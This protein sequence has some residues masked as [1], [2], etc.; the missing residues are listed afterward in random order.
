VVGSLTEVVATLLR[1]IAMNLGLYSQCVYM[2]ISVDYS[3]FPSKP[4]LQQEIGSKPGLN[5]ILERAN[6]HFPRRVESIDR[7]LACEFQKFAIDGYC[8]YC[9]AVVLSAAFRRFNRRRSRRAMPLMI[10][11]AVRTYSSPALRE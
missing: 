11:I 1:Q 4:K 2:S 10:S 7:L 8:D 6:A 3:R 9:R 5:Q